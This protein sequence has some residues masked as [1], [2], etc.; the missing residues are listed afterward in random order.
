MTLCFKL[1]I[2]DSHRI[3]ENHIFLSLC[4]WI[5]L[6]FK[7]FVSSGWTTAEKKGLDLLVLPGKT[8]GCS[9]WLN[10]STT[11]YPLEKWMKKTSP[12]QLRMECTCGDKG[13]STSR[14]CWPLWG[15][16]SLHR[17]EHIRS[18]P[19]F[20][21]VLKTCLWL[22]KPRQILAESECV[23]ISDLVWIKIMLFT[24][25]SWLCSLTT[26]LFT[27]QGDHWHGWMRSS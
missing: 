4:V 6:I 5:F 26:F 8:Y 13:S 21:I 17:L 11:P 1:V 7:D 3:T 24:W 18:C 12:L 10:G 25:F 2:Q 23:V 15:L 14:E 9:I 19:S 16:I 20:E 27:S 22:A